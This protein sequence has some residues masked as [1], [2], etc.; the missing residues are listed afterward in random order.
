MLS[1]RKRELGTRLLLES[2]REVVNI[3]E[4]GEKGIR[5]ANHGAIVLVEGDLARRGL[6]N[7][8]ETI[9]ELGENDASKGKDSGILRGEVLAVVAPMLANLGRISGEGGL[10][11]DPDALSRETDH[12]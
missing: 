4:H 1:E 8:T 12:R 3:V 10:N 7:A 5:G 6:F 2:T 11:K 9:S